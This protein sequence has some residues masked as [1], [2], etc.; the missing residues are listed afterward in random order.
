MVMLYHH[1]TQHERGNPF[2]FGTGHALAAG[3][4]PSVLA[5]P[6]PLD[7]LV[8]D[9]PTGP[10]DQQLRREALLAVVSG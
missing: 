4:E 9:Q 3:P 7:P 10:G 2:S 8:V 6:D 5:S 1:A